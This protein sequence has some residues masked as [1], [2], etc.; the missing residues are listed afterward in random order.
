MSDDGIDLDEVKKRATEIGL[1]NLTDNHLEQLGKA[2][3]GTQERLRRIPS[4]LHMYEEPAH[5]FR[6]DEEG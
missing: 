4:D 6:A 1:T 3:K 2:D 5:T